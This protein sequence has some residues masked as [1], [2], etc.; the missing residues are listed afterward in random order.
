MSTFDAVEQAEKPA[1]QDGGVSFA[2]RRGPLLSLVLKNTLLTIVTLG[3]YRFWA[4]TWIRQYFWNNVRIAGDLVEYVGLAKELFIG[5]L[6]AIAV[7]FPLGII[8]NIVAA[9]LVSAPEWWQAVWGLTYASVIFLLIQFAIYRML[10][11]RLTRTVWR[12]I[13]F[14]L[15]GSTTQFV[16][17]ALGWTILTLLT[18][19]LA[20]PWMRVAL[21]RYRINNARYGST[22]FEFDGS[23]RALIGVWLINY[24]ILIA[25][26]V[27]FATLPPLGFLL[28]AVAI[29]V[30]TFYRVREF[31]YFVGAT[32]IAGVTFVSFANTT[33]IFWMYGLMLI[34]MFAGIFIIFIIVGAAVGFTSAASGIQAVPDLSSL[35][36]GF[37]AAP[38][39]WIGIA[40]AVPLAFVLSQR[41][42]LALLFQHPLMVHICTTLTIS[43]PA[44]LDQVV[45]STEP[46][47]GFGE[48]LADAFD[49]G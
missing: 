36:A 3:I 22:K 18:L 29:F 16:L 30:F 32:S 27:S 49:V 2:G 41:V 7:L 48:G 11:Y 10:R 21:T 12:G 19:G 37:E 25:A 8:Y 6:I 38:G 26:A 39:L 47:P 35:E 40:I 46:T 14:G 1:S 13:R 45:R 28:V 23:G 31:R 5:F 34:A 20:L 44:V 15:D 33:R 24:A 42:V 17:L 9:L 4:K 43:D